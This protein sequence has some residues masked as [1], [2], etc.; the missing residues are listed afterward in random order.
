MIT[1]SERSNVIAEKA[2]LEG[3]IRSLEEGLLPE[4]VEKIE[5]ILKDLSIEFK[6]Q[7]IFEK[8]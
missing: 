8:Y 7:Y 6:N 1:G 4:V 2:F 3:T 5:N